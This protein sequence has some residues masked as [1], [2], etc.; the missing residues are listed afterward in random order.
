MKSIEILNII[1]ETLEYI[2]IRMKTLNW[3]LE[4]MKENENFDSQS[5]ETWRKF[6]E[7]V[8]DYNRKRVEYLLF[9]E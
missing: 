8:E 7:V 4:E 5:K 2:I 9:E 1:I 6:I 3:R